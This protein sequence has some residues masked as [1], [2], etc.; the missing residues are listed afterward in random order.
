MSQP[1]VNIGMADNFT[2]E[3]DAGDLIFLRLWFAERGKA[4]PSN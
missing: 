3:K 4:L 1:L 2:P